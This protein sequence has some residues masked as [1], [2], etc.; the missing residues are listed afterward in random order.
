MWPPDVER[1]AV[2][3]RSAGVEGR[4]EELPLDETSIPAPAVRA[5]A[6]DCDGR[7]VVALVPADRDVDRGKLRTALRC[8]EIRRL[9]TPSFPYPKASVVIERLVLGEET[10]WVEAGS[11]RHVASLT[12]AGLVEL[13][14]AETADLVAEA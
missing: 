3:L 8:R 7:T 13:T 9:D 4:L 1:I 5:E 6:Y 14:H 10:I 12:P 11:P 2:L